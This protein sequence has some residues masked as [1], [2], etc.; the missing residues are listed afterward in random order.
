MFRV[1]IAYGLGFGVWDIGL[2]AK[3]TLSRIWVV[4]YSCRPAIRVYV[5]ADDINP[6]SP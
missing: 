4:A 6:A 2:R 1:S 3:L 5:T